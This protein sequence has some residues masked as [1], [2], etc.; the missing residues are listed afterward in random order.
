M[1]GHDSSRTSTNLDEKTLGPSVL[2][3]LAPAWQAWIGSESG[4]ASNSTPSILQGS[5]Y[6]GS[7]VDSGPNLLA[8]DA[9]TGGPLW[10]ARVGYEY[11]PQCDPDENV[12]VPSTAAVSGGTVV[13][14]GGDAAYYGLDARTGARLWRKPLDAGPSGFAWASP[15]LADGR[16]YYGA[17]SQ[18]DNPPVPGAVF[19]VGAADGSTLAIQPMTPPNSLGGGGVWNS[20]A[21][22]PD[23]RTLVVATG[24][25]DGDN[26]PYEQAL[27][28]L[29]AQTLRP[30]QSH[31]P[32]ILGTDVDFA[33][34]PVVFHDSSGR[35]MTGATSKNGVFY[36][37]FIDSVSAGPVWS[38]DFG[39]VIGMAPAYDSSLGPSGTL[40]VV[41]TDRG[42]TYT[43]GNAAIY[44]VDP[45]TGADVWA[46]RAVIGNAGSNLAIANRLIFVNTG[47][48]GVGVL[49]ET[50]GAV[51][52]SLLPPNA[53][54]AVSG[55]AVAEGAVY[56]VSGSYL[57]AWRVP[58]P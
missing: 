9:R 26:W 39:V 10:G 4:I 45:E 49:D 34:S 42:A 29:D 46:Q 15:A 3:A 47:A 20:P 51:L 18:C 12:G 33:G 19:S 13:L 8:F 40:F 23:G 37:Y 17:A 36:A 1:Y 53:G 58:S 24:E 32:R 31:K 54:P 38:R 21:L 2:G 6:V 16:A 43:G 52:R 56:W 25:D 5:V 7:S 50:N 11:T 14:G 28:T 55:I 48:T 27:V 35:A 57:N 22:T 30:L 41:G 44:A